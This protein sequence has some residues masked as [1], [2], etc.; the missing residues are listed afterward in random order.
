M[1]LRVVAIADVAVGL[2]RK[3]KGE[4]AD[5][6]LRQVVHQRFVPL[7]LPLNHG[8]FPFASDGEISC[9]IVWGGSGRS[10]PAGRALKRW[11]GRANP[12][13]RSA[14]S[15]RPSILSAQWIGGAVNSAQ[16]FF[17]AICSLSRC[18]TAMKRAVASCRQL[19]QSVPP[20]SMGGDLAQLPYSFKQSESSARLE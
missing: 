18:R 13:G 12:L 17:S 3:V 16:C 9:S 2:T 4:S 8:T 11:S 5:L 6:L 7:D 15:L 20:C 1:M 19:S 10:L 14:R